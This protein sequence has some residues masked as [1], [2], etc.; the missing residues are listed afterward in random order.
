MQ[1]SKNKILFGFFK[2]AKLCDVHAKG[3]E[4]LTKTLIC[5]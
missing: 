3:D 2:K 4:M 5:P 1:F